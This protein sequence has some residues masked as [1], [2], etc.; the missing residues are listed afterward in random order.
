MGNDQ[1]VL[2]PRAEGRPDPGEIR[3][4]RGSVPMDAVNVGKAT[5]VVI[6]RRTDQKRQLA[7]HLTVLDADQADLTNAPAGW[8]CG[9]EVDSGEGGARVHF[10]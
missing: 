1:L 9:L 2:N 10:S 6:V 5:P 8:T 7:H 4:A 3:C